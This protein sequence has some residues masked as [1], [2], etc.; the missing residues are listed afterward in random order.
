MTV[1]KCVYRLRMVGGLM[2]LTISFKMIAEAILIVQK[3]LYQEYEIWYIRRH[4]INYPNRS[5]RTNVSD[6]ISSLRE[7]GQNIEQHIFMFGG[8]QKYL[9]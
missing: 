7:H 8:P 5:I 3:Y 1:I 4:F 2:R 6:F 9:K